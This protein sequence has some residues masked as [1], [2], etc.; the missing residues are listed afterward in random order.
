M[1]QISQN[2][3]MNFGDPCIGGNYAL[4]H[5]HHMHHM[6]QCS[7]VVLEVGEPYAAIWYLN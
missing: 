1:Q 4:F 3:E 6:Q 7:N 2:L 5:V